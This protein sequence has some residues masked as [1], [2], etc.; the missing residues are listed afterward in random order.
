[1]NQRGAGQMA[2][3]Q[4]GNGR[5]MRRSGQGQYANPDCPYYDQTNP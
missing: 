4:M 1:M 2:G 3:G 5:G